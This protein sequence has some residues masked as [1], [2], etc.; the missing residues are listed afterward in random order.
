MHRTRRHTLLLQQAH[1]PVQ[2]WDDLVASLFQACRNALNLCVPVVDIPLQPLVET[3]KIVDD[4]ALLFQTC[5]L[6]VSIVLLRE[7][8]S[9]VS[10]VYASNTYSKES[11]NVIES[12]W[13]LNNRL[14][15]SIELNAN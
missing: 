14:W 4:L 1:D 8:S 11:K 9:K 12:G 3:S 2:H 13:K 5:K 10:P 7:L 15:T 6:S